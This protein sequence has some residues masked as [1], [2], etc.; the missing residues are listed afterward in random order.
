VQWD[1]Y[2]LVIITETWWDNSRDWSA[3]TDGYKCFRRDKQ[4]KRGG[5]VALCVRDSFNCME[6]DNCDD[7]VECL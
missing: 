4:G 1:S 7:K 3:A 2:D 5:E 6:L